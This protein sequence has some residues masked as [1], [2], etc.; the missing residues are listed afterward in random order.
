MIAGMVGGWTGGWRRGW[1]KIQWMTR[2]TAR[3]YCWRVGIVVV[4]AAVA[5]GKDDG[6]KRSI[7]LSLTG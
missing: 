6:G 7:E 4:N 1:Y 3:E 2:F 5:G